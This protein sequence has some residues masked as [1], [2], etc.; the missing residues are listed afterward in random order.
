MSWAVGWDVEHQRWRGYGVP[1]FCDATGCGV[2]IDRGLAHVCGCPFGEEDRLGHTIFLCGQH[3]CSDV[4]EDNLPPEHP[5]WLQHVLTDESW[6]QWRSENPDKVAAY[7]TAL[8]GSD[9]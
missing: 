9:G 3:D 7:T 8:G 2:E 5:D 4:D 1:A 6:S